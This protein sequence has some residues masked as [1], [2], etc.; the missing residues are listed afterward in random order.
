MAVKPILRGRQF[1]TNWHD[2]T[3]NIFFPRQLLEV[4]DFRRA[5]QRSISKCY[6]GLT[7]GQVIGAADSKS[8]GCGCGAWVGAFAAPVRRGRQ[9]RVYRYEREQSW[10]AAVEFYAFNTR[11]TGRGGSRQFHRDPAS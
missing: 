5:K 10:Q 2:Q 7:S 8:A 3:A 1:V 9:P 4:L 6:L 11:C